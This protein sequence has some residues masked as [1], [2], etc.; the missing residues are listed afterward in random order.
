MK[1]IFFN[2]LMKKNFFFFIL[3]L[4]LTISIFIVSMVYFNC[5]SKIKYII[6]NSDQ[7][8]LKIVNFQNLIT[9]FKDQ[10]D[11]FKKV[12]LKENEIKILEKIQYLISTL[13]IEQTENTI[14]QPLNNQLSYP[15]SLPIRMITEEIFLNNSNS[16]ET[17]EI[18]KYLKIYDLNAPNN[19]TFECVKTAMI[20]VQTTICIHNID[21]DIYVSKSLKYNGIWE[22][23]IVSLFMKILE[24]NR[25]FNVFDIG[26]NLGQFCLYAAKFNRKCIAIEPFY[27]NFIR[28]HKSAQIENLSNNIILITNGVS[29]KRGQVKRLQKN[30]INIGGQGILENEKTKIQNVEIALQDKYNLVTVLLNDLINI[31]PIDFNEAII[32]I[33]IENHEM[34]AFKRID[35]LLSR[36]KINA[37][38]MEWAGKAELPLDDVIG[39]LEFM[40][41]NDYK[42]KSIQLSDLI[43]E[44]WRQWPNDIIWFRNGFK[45]S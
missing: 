33:D 45:L 31:I 12:N 25:N 18:K 8:D 30:D 38:I 36:V 2:I 19:E 35:R 22:S 42:P 43:K 24:Q 9:N 11:H 37:I 13:I 14:T 23:D 21:K 32:K 1:I 6:N 41:S 3:T 17:E 4:L 5:Y 7:I 10:L 26:A 34:K 39:F 16:N 29:D 27:D 40:F 28:L 15:L 20:I 44:E